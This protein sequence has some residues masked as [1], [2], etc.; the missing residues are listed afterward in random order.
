MLEIFEVVFLGLG[1]LFLM[2]I[3]GTL[4]Q[5]RDYLENKEE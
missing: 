5:L 1:A 4:I 3:S 2:Q